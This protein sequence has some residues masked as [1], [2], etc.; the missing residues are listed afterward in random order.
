MQRLFAS[1]LALILL[2]TPYA[3]A[4]ETRPEYL[5]AYERGGL[6]P[7]ANPIV[8]RDAHT[9]PPELKGLRVVE[10]EVDVRSTDDRDIAARMKTAA[11]VAFRDPRVKAAAGARFVVLGGGMLDPKKD[12]TGLD[13]GELAVD[14]YNYERN[15][16]YRA[17]LVGD[18][19]VSLRAQPEGYQPKETRAEVQAAAAIVAKDP[20]HARTV[21]GLIA[22]G[23]RAPSEGGDRLLYVLFYRGKER[24]ALYDATVN[25]S[26]ARV[27]HAG[28]ITAS[29][30]R[31]EK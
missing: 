18:D 30:T 22:R 7:I 28:P 4:Q 29:R 12:E 19:V 6:P 14:F 16:A 17:V 11:A 9:F 10:A 1:S 27:V 26:D 23:L 8:F 21:A 24:P 13:K 31:R 5:K 20:K 25:M 2:P 15:L 3:L